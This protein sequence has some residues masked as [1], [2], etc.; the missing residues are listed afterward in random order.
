MKRRVN[1]PGVQLRI[2]DKVATIRLIGDISYMR[3]GS[4]EIRVSIDAP[5]SIAIKREELPDLDEDDNAT[6]RDHS[7]MR[8]G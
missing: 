3:D 8:K 7:R 4:Q 6:R 2:G 5:R 1:G